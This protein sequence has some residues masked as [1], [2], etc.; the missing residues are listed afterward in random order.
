MNANEL[1]QPKIVLRTATLADADD[2]SRF[3]ARVFDETFGHT[4]TPE[5][6]SQYIAD[7]YNP[8]IQAEEIADSRA[9]LFLGEDHSVKGA[10]LA[11][12]AHLIV[13]TDAASIELKRIYVNSS[14]HGR[15]VARCLLDEVLAECRRRCAQRLWLTVWHQNHRAIAFYNKSVGYSSLFLSF[16]YFLIFFSFILLYNFIYM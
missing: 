2:V 3:A 13:D 11:G 16:F 8:A 4:A 15:G 10:P 5:D 9:I 1:S 6:M 12:Y 7:A 14:W